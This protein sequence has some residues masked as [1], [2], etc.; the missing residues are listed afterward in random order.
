MFGLSIATDSTDQVVSLQAARDHARIYDDSKETN[1]DVDRILTAATR[2]TE[3]YIGHYLL[4]ITVDWTFHRFPVKNSDYDRVL[5]PPS[6]PLRGVTSIKY[7]DEDNDQQTLSSD[8][9]TVDTA[10]MP[11]RI[12]EAYDCEWPDTVDR[13]DAVV[14]RMTIGYAT[15]SA[16]PDD[17]KHAILMLFGHWYRN[18]EMVITGTIANEIAETWKAILDAH[19]FTMVG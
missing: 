14:V 18:R 17:I 12:Y 6:P 10:S 11:G 4:P 7:Y 13:L 19:K 15:V 8:E 9:Y 16:I 1:R 5:Y 3:R 2:R